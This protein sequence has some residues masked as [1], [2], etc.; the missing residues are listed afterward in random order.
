MMTPLFLY[1]LYS[2]KETN[3]DGLYNIII[4]VF[5]LFLIFVLI[6]KDKNKRYKYTENLNF[7]NS[8]DMALKKE[9]PNFTDENINL[10]K[11]GLKEY[12]KL[13]AL[14]SRGKIILPSLVVNLALK[15]FFKTVEYQD[16]IKNVFK[17]Y[18][19][20]VLMKN[21]NIIDNDL[22]VVWTLTCENENIN[23]NKPDKLPLIFSI[24]SQLNI[25]NGF[26]FTIDESNDDSSINVNKIGSVSKMSVYGGGGF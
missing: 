3:M 17:F 4:S 15:E 20:D 25:E 23:P 22:K 26:R 18:F 8:I 21:N 16:F 12:L 11:Q 2:L 14:S 9:F 19:T 13:Y 1:S 6:R 24:D 5:V 10:V 7:P